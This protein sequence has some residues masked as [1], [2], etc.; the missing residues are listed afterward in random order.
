MTATDTPLVTSPETR[1]SILREGRHDHP[2]GFECDRC[3]GVGLAIDEIRHA[4]GC[5]QAAAG[6]RRWPVRE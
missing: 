4:P 5:P 6:W 1:F 3:G 2:T